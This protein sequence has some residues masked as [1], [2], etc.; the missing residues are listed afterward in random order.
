VPRC[1]FYMLWLCAVMRWNRHLVFCIFLMQATA[2]AVTP[3]APNTALKDAIKSR[4]IL[5]RKSNKTASAVKRKRGYLAVRVS[6]H[7]LPRQA[8]EKS[9]LRPQFLT[10]PVLHQRVLMLSSFFLHFG[11]S[12]SSCAVGGGRSSQTYVHNHK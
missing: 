8:G 2:H 5:T 9:K 7:R 3:R 12:R 11:K 4:D 6:L 10:D 1:H